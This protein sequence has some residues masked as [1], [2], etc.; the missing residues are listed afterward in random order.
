M[1]PFALFNDKDR[2]V[3]VLIDK[4]V[5]AASNVTFHPMQNDA[6]IELLA[7]DLKRFLEKIGKSFV[8]IDFAAVR[9]GSYQFLYAG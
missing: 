4:K 7:D 2:K 8:I 6:L 3:R 5:M 9:R 1:N